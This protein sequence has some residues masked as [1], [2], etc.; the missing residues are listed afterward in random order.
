MLEKEDHT[1]LP[2]KVPQEV[3]IVRDPVLN[4][5]KKA[6]LNREIGINLPRPFCFLSSRSV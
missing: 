5:Q 3:E 2:A 6:N 1:A 4:L